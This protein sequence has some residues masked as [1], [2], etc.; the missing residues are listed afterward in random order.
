MDTVIISVVGRFPTQPPTT[1]KLSMEHNWRQSGNRFTSPRT[2]P[3]TERTEQLFGCE[4]I[5]GGGG[6]GSVYSYNELSLVVAY[7]WLDRCQWIK[8]QDTTTNSGHFSMASVCITGYWL[9]IIDWLCS[10][11]K[12]HIRM[13]KDTIILLQFHFLRFISG[14]PH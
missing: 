13:K 14:G 5:T 12:I 9:W 8:I 3:R 2:E 4:E 6:S 10:P 1:A 7:L 11:N